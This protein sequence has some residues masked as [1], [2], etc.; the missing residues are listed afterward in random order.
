MMQTLRVNTGKLIIIS[1]PSG[2]GK[3]TVVKELLSR[4]RLPLQLSVSATT[5][6]PRPGEEDG[7]DYHF[8]SA[9]EFQ[10]RRQDNAFLE[11]KE[12]FGRGHW[13]GTLREPVLTGIRQGVWI[14]LEIDVQ[15]A[16]SVLDEYPEA[17]S[18]FVHPG[19]MVELERRLRNRQTEDESAIQRRLEVARDEMA[20][21]QKYKYEIVNHAVDQTVE[22]IQQLLVQHQ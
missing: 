15:G 4:Q 9:E 3:S 21:R 13:Y 18:I 8:L 7:R 19:S 11:C 16:V 17:I 22:T 14:I 6:P 10:K 12:V 5:R 20:F 1:G 2:A